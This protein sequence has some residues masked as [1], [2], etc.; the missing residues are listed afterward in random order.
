MCNR[1]KLLVV[2]SFLFV[3]TLASAQRF[4]DRVRV[5]VF[6]QPQYVWILNGEDMNAGSVYSYEM[7]PDNAFGANFEY[8]INNNWSFLVE[9]SYSGQGTGYRSVINAGTDQEIVY[10]GKKRLKYAKAAL[11][12][13]YHYKFRPRWTIAWKFGPQLGYLTSVGGPVVG[14]EDNGGGPGDKYD[15]PLADFSHYRRLSMEFSGAMGVEFRAMKKLAVFLYVNS[16]IGFNDIENKDATAMLWGTEQPV[17]KTNSDDRPASR[18]FTVGLQ[19]GVSYYFSSEIT[20]LQRGSPYK[21]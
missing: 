14:Y 3:T 6:Y 4:A 12:L 2:L 9:G 18:N 20:N 19:I 15:N 11:L 13:S 10:T 17:Y 16:D 1:K 8:W 7:A 5:G 21:F